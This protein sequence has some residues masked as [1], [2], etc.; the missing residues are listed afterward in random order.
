[1]ADTATEVARL[2]SLCLDTLQGR[3]N[4]SL[5]YSVASLITIEEILAEA[6]DF[7]ADLTE[8]QITGL[9]EK[10]GCYILAVGQKQFGG[11]YFWHD[12]RAQPVL[13]VGEPDKHIAILT[14]DRVRG[15]LSGDEG[16]NIP[17]FY[18]GFAEHAA[19]APAGTH[20]LY[21]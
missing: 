10:V 2:A 6:A 7:Y 11:A 12:E 19:T 5:D 18:Q 14:W 15:R 4:G 3:A 8:T 1:M 9:V 17:F 13:V 20:V 16:D 21:V